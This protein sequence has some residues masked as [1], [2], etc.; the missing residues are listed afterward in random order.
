[1]DFAGFIK[2]VADSGVRPDEQV[3]VL[4]AFLAFRDTAKAD[5]DSILAK[6][7][8]QRSYYTSRMID[9]DRENSYLRRQLDDA[10]AYGRAMRVFYVDSEKRF[11]ELERENE[12]LKAALAEARAQLPAKVTIDLGEICR[13]AHDHD[14]RII[15][16]IKEVRNSDKLIVQSNGLKPGLRFVKMVCEVVAAYEGTGGRVLMMHAPGL[17]VTTSSPYPQV[18][19]EINFLAMQEYPNHQIAILDE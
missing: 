5:Y 1:M 17:S 7:Q 6:Y 18:R 12:Q 2:A 15:N 16:F 8:E 4:K 10:H 9:S 19:R 3:A 14:G 13:L 11:A